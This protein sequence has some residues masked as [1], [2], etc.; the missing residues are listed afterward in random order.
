MKDE[1]TQ[2]EKGASPRPPGLYMAVI[3]AG[4]AFVGYKAVIVFKAVPSRFPFS[5]V[6]VALVIAFFAF[7]LLALYFG[8]R[9]ARNEIIA[10]GA[11]HGALASVQRFGLYTVG[12]G[13]TMALFILIKLAEMLR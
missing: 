11:P 9:R 12:A 13:Y 5:A 7:P 10:C 8:Y 4:A 2:T 3:I 1:P 6:D